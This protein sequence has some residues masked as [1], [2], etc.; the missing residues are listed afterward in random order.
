MASDWDGE[1]GSLDAVPALGQRHHFCPLWPV[2][3]DALPRPS[4][5]E[6]LA[7]AT[8]GLACDM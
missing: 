8:A 1:Q 7:P 4:H 3:R 2:I 6:L 5:R